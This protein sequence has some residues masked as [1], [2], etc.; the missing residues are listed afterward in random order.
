MAREGRGFRAGSAG[1]GVTAAGVQAGGQ[2]GSLAWALA[3][4]LAVAAHLTLG[5]L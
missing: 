3:V 1:R 5:Q 4:M 2:P